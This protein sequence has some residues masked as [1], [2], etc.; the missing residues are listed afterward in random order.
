MKNGINLFK[1]KTT[2]TKGVDMEKYQ[3]TKT[4]RFKLLLTLKQIPPN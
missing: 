3:I 2:K 4:I 1:T